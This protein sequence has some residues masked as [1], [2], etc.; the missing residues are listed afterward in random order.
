[1]ILNYITFKNNKKF[2]KWQEKNK[3]N[4]HTVTPIMNNININMEQD[5]AQTNGFGET[6][7]GVFVL[8]SKVEQ[9]N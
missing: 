8:Y 4:V 3:V 7:F 9:G 6:E 5:A 1:M 2:V